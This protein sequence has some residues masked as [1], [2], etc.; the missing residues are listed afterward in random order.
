MSVTAIQKISWRPAELPAVTGLS[1]AFWRKAI[2]Q[3][4]IKSRRVGT[5]VIIL[6]S[7]LREFLK[8]K[9]AGN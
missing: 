9:E 7:D 2:Q 8:G 1:L 6:D 5:A 4:K 3:K